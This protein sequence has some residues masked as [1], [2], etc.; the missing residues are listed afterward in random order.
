MSN[1]RSSLIGAKKVVQGLS[2]LVLGSA[3]V[4]SYLFQNMVNAIPI[5]K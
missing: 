4:G 1:C 5:D 3:G 2:L